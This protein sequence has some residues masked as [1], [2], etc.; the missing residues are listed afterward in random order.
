MAPA[1]GAL[2]SPPQARVLAGLAGCLP[3]CSAVVAFLLL[4]GRSQFPL[5]W[6]LSPPCA[7]PGAKESC[8]GAFPGAGI[9]TLFK[10][11]GICCRALLCLMNAVSSSLL[12]SPSPTPSG[13]SLIRLR[14][15]PR[16]AGEHQL[17]DACALSAG[18]PPLPLCPPCLS[19]VPKPVRPS[20]PCLPS[21]RG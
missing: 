21:L 5:Q 16:L 3:L 2:L 15:R 20:Q 12:Q 17:Q 7:S 19:S 10:E 14:S 11:D 18:N 9:R 4:T 13:A 6:P 1:A 8:T